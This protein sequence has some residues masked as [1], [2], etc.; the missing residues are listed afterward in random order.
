MIPNLRIPQ[1]YTGTSV[2]LCFTEDLKKLI[3][4]FWSIHCIDLYKYSQYV[5]Y[6]QVHE[7]EQVPDEGEEKL[8]WNVPK[9]NIGQC[10]SF[11]DMTERKKNFS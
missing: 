9:S 8:F 4:I 1:I 11:A 6:N 7:E 3:M 5:Y 10:I 2:A